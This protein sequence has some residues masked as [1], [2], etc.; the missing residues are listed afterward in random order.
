MAYRKAHGAH[1]KNHPVVIEVSPADELPQAVLSP[2]PAVQ[3]VRRQNGTVADS[4]SAKALGAKGGQKRA[5][6][7]RL[8]S[9][10][11]IRL[12]EGAPFRPYQESAEDFLLAHLSELASVSGGRVDPGAA[13]ISSTACMQLAASRFLFD[14]ACKSGDAV[15]L[16]QASALANDSRQNLLASYEL[17]V[18]MAQSRKAEPYDILAEYMP[19]H[20]EDK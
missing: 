4:K 11:G 6:R 16:K 15:M 10:I 18:R 7:A 2:V 14:I 5:Q 17:S 8:M 12:P 1:A 3:I 19:S 9:G 13:S 20:D